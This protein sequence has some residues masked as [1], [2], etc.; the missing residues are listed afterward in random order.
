MAV[1]VGRDNAQ[2]ATEAWPAP[3]LFTWTQPALPSA[4]TV[5][6]A[7]NVARFVRD[8]LTEEYSV[9]MDGVR[10]DFI[11]QQRPDGEGELRVE[12]DVTGATAEPLVNGVRLVL[13]SSK[14]KLAYNRLRVVDTED[15]SCQRG[16]R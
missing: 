10:Q 14:R 13:D 6:V 7:N 8:G 1:K 2:L 9:S 4:G 5:N 16:W 15:A 11:L 3:G 12:L